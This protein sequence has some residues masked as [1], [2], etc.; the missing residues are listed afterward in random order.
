MQRLL[1]WIPTAGDLYRNRARIAGF[2]FGIFVPLVLGALFVVIYTG[3]GI[4][5][6]PPAPP[7]VYPDF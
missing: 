1:Q 4:G 6:T 5:V 7:P 3:H 2:A